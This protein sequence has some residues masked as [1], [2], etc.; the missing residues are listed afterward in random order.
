[1]IGVRGWEAPAM[2]SLFSLHLSPAIYQ[3]TACFKELTGEITNT[4][5]RR[6]GFSVKLLVLASNQWNILYSH[7]SNP[8]HVFLFLP[9]LL[10][11]SHFLKGSI[12]ILRVY[13]CDTPVYM[14]EY[15]CMGVCLHVEVDVFSLWLCFGEVR[16]NVGEAL[17]APLSGWCQPV[18]L[19]TLPFFGP[20]LLFK[21]LFA[22]LTY[23]VKPLLP[24]CQWAGLTVLLTLQL[25]VC[26]YDYGHPFLIA[27]S[28][29]W[30]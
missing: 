30:N 3:I 2:S 11:G 13:V 25:Q 15:W 28:T 8:S 17:A 27:V 29:F 14:C 19:C 1:M 16:C 20:T 24:L 21:H 23:P 12:Q 9:V 6:G 18:C 26:L 5:R 10:F 7:L 4:L 22:A